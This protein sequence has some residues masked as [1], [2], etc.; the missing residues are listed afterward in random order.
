MNGL[1]SVFSFVLMALTV[2]VLG[3]A[4]TGS[5]Q[6]TVTD[7]SGAVVQG[8]DVVVRNLDT[9]QERTARSSGSGTYDEFA[10]RQ[11]RNHGEQ[12]RLPIL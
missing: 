7:A 11:V 12:G 3:H 1:K 6:G 8:A 5:I 10:C 2:S 9:N 4:Q